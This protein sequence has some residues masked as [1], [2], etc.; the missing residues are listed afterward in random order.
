MKDRTR[1]SLDYIPTYASG[2]LELV[3]L[4]GSYEAHS[5]GH[6]KWFTP[7]YTERA[8]KY[9]NFRLFKT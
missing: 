2:F 6:L 8:K 5:E 4:E 9:G 7:V 3:K 1:L